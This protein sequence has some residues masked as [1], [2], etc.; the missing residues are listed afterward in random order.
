MCKWIEWVATIITIT[1]AFLTAFDYHPFNLYVLNAGSLLWLIWGLLEHKP[2][3]ALV[4]GVMLLIYITGM[5]RPLLPAL[6]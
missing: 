5:F 2:S 3:I 4:N 1:G 6:L